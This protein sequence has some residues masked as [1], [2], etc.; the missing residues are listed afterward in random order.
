MKKACF[1]NSIALAV[2][3]IG[4][5]IAG[6]ALAEKPPWAGGGKDKSDGPSQKWESKGGPVGHRDFGKDDNGSGKG[7]DKDKH[8]DK[9]SKGKDKD[10]DKEKG[11][12]N[13]SNRKHQKYFSSDKVVII[14]NYYSGQY[15][16]A[17]HCPP[18]LAKKHNGCMPRD[19]R[20]SGRSA[21][22]SRVRLSTMI[23]RPPWSYS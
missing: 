23:S 19:R 7:K 15:K 10:R 22:L 8:K 18:G 13:D 21:D 11:K 16:K 12:Y 1:Q 4:F 20:R 5:L 9:Y 3:L 6:P 2:L 17:R 14:N